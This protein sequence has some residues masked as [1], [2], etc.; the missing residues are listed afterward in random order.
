MTI[1]ISIK[2]NHFKEVLES[3]LVTPERFRPNLAT[4]AKTCGIHG[5]NV[6]I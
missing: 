6:M 1:V 2:L 4:G 5:I 3:T